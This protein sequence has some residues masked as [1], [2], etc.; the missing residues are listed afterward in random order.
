[1]RGRRRRKRKRKRKRGWTE[2]EEV[3]CPRLL[4]LLGLSVRVRS[5]DHPKFIYPHQ[6]PS[7][8]PSEFSDT[9]RT[10]SPTPPRHPYPCTRSSIFPSGLG[11]V[12]D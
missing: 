2:T 4:L 10:Q 1:M 11:P 5:V 9:H 7:L 3:L 6:T 8:A 12:Q